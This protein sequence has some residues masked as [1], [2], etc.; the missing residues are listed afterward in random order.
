MVLSSS[1]KPLLLTSST[2]RTISEQED[3][4][5]KYFYSTKQSF[6][7]FW[8]NAY[9]AVK[10]M[11]LPKEHLDI[12]LSSPAM[13]VGVDLDNLTDAIMFKAI[14]NIA[15]YRQKVGRI[16][17]ERFRDTYSSMLA[18]FRAIDYHYYRNPTP[19][20]NND[21]LEAIPLAVDNIELR[22]QAAFHAIFDWITLGFDGKFVSNDIMSMDTKNMKSVIE[23]CVQR[24]KKNR[25]EI[26]R[27]LSINLG[28]NNREEVIFPAIQQAIDF[29]AIFVK[30]IS[31]LLESS[32]G[33]CLADF[34]K[35]PARQIKLSQLGT[36]YR[37]LCL[38]IR[39]DFSTI[40]SQSPDL[41]NLE[42]DGIDEFVDALISSWNDIE[43]GTKCERIEEI[44]SWF[45]ENNVRFM[46]TVMS[47]PVEKRSLLMNCLNMIVRLD[48]TWDQIMTSNDFTK[49]LLTSGHIALGI[50]INDWNASATDPN[51]MNKKWYLYDLASS[52]H[53]TKHQRPFIFPE[54]LF[55]PPN[56][57]KVT[58][59][60]P[61]RGEDEEKNELLPI[62]EVL[63]AYAPGMWTY[64]K[65]GRPM[66]SKAY[67]RLLETNSA[68]RLQLPIW[69]LR[70][71]TAG[72]SGH[73]FIE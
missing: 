28:E 13:E 35:R 69:E 60:F 63:M 44:F 37:D 55:E 16:G 53:M 19:L 9:N 29:W 72:K 59:W 70:D 40:V 50:S 33:K 64:R 38:D 30:D 49:Q 54:N 57:K 58:T 4:P 8:N 3:D 1:V 22:K 18:S 56:I 32:H 10:K 25:S 26:T 67:K 14:R 27:Y 62:T 7:K 36:K 45:K 2:I 66:K 61:G 24:L 17:R 31:P 52:L 39:D 43:T 68:D 11:D 46:Q 71:E 47:S 21:R 5:N 6:Y 23:D 15:S 12:A 73:K 51:E 34:M 42:L 48:S 65:D 20:L 41:R